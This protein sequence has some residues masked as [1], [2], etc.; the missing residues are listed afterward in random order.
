MGYYTNYTI[1]VLN[2]NGDNI[3]DEMESERD[4][5]DIVMWP[6]DYPPE[7]D[8]IIIDFLQGDRFYG[9]LTDGN[10]KWYD[11]EEV[12]KDLSI[13]YPG[14]IF[15]LKGVGEEQGDIWAKYFYNGKMKSVKPTLQWPYFSITEFVKGE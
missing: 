10:C 6:N 3:T 12:M 1:Q 13:K 4:F 8:D 14:L 2:K 5:E 11:H 9:L 15:M 7:I